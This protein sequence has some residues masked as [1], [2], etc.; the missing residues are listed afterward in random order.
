MDLEM[1]MMVKEY[2]MINDDDNDDDILCLL[3]D[4]LFAYIHITGMS[5]SHR[6]IILIIIIPH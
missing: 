1:M 3:N 5:L 2:V 6:M 4:D